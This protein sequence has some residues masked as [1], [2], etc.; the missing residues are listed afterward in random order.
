VLIVGPDGSGKSTLAR[1]LVSNV[2]R[3][4]A[5]VRHMH[6]RPGVLPRAGRIVGS[7]A[8]DPTRP[9]AEEPHGKVL[10]LGLLLYDWLDFFLGGWLRIVPIRQRGGLVVMERG[11]MDI[12][13]DP[14]RYHLTVSER[15]VRLL[16]WPLP[17]PDLT[18][19][20]Y[21]SPELL[22][23]RTDELPESELARQVEAWRR[24]PL[25][26]GSA[27]VRLDATSPERDI[28]DRAT[29]LILQESR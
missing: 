24:I 9:H 26:R 18:I 17:R 27:Q 3:W 8:G 7:R 14:R 20:L 6:W 15:L 11:W 10:S 16:A 5:S 2:G 12:A 21:G 28:L 25:P 29:R 22:A 23:A 13:V 19:V 1:G 4:F